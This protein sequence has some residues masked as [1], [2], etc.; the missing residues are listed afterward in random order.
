MMCLL[1]GVVDEWR[2]DIGGGIWNRFFN[3]ESV[4]IIRHII[5]SDTDGKKTTFE[6]LYKAI[7]IE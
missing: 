1:H 7:N 3:L 2:G 5:N 6:K 4:Q